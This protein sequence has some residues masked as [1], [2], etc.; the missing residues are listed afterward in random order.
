M[1]IKG[2]GNNKGKA[3]GRILFSNEPISF[4]GGIDPETGK[5]V[6]EGHELK[7]EKVKDKILVFPKGKGSTVGSYVLYQL[8]KNNKEPSAIINSESEAIVAVGAII[9]SIP[10]IDKIDINKL[11]KKGMIS[12][13]S[14][15]GTV[16][17]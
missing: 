9:S 10:L 7:G 17:F 8:S 12:V 14:E 2:R 4:L 13:D 6:E 11:P 15:E 16:K 5:I 3:Q 1:K